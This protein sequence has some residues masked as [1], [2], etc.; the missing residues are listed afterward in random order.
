MTQPVPLRAHKLSANAALCVSGFNLIAP[1]SPAIE[2]MT[3]FFRVNVVSIG[4]AATVDEANARMISRGVRLLMVVGKDDEVVG[5]ITARDILGEKPLQVA[6]ARGGK[7][8]E[9]SV[10]DLMTPIGGIDTLALD[11]VLRARVSDILDAL[12]QLGRQHILVEDSDPL[13]GQPRVRGLFSAT[14]IG[15]ALGVPVLGFDLPR[16]FAEIEAALVN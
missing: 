15:R 2:A 7:R 13:S 11:D 6:Q 10:A 16:T 9:L 1:D 14:Q 3:D 8:G 5:L 4:P 12:K